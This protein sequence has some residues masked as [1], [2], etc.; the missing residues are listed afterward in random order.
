MS[1]L[2][3]QVLSNQTSA[4]SNP[5]EGLGMRLLLGLVQAALATVF[6]P[7]LFLILALVGIY[8]AFEWVFL[9]GDAVIRRDDLYLG[10]PAALRAP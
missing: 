6:L 10:Q 8:M 2:H 1:N 9:R 7:A 4:V 5:A 3:A